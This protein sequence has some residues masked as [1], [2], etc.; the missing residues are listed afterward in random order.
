ME[1]IYSMT[2]QGVVNKSDLLA[3]DVAIQIFLF[4]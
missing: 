3:L 1:M 2:F 4:L